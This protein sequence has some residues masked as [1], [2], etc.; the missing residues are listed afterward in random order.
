MTQTQAN[1]QLHYGKML[2]D[3]IESKGY[4]IGRIA[5]LLDMSV[6]TLK[7]RLRDGAFTIDELKKLYSNRYLPYD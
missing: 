6:N 3:E 2:R 1:Q 5:E 4:K 7:S